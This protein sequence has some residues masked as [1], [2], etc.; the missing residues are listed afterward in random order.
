MNVSLTDK[1]EQF[2]AEQVNSG[3]Y[4][5]ASEVVREG[6]RLLAAREEGERMKLDALR[7]L[8][9]EGL[10]SGPAAPLDVEEILAAARAER[11][12]RAE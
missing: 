10:E 9:R 3:R 12:S 6:L 1:L 8:I 2:V 7:Q 11:A 5:S 4:Q